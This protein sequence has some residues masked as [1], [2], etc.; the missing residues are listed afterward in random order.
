MG[1]GGEHPV[2][3]D[4]SSASAL[5]VLS[6]ATAKAFDFAQ[7]VTKQ[8]LTLATGILA[9]TITFIKD[10]A[11]HA[12]RAAEV[13]MGLSWVAYLVSVVFGLWTLMALTGTLQ[14]LRPDNLKPSI[15]GINVRRPATLQL[16]CFFVALVLSVWAGIRTL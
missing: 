3:A 5:K 10:F 4:D 16:A 7:D 13:L 6:D 12:P 8:V 1:A 2:N 14:P 9:L 15:Q 11:N